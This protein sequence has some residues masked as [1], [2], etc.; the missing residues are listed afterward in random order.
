MPVSKKRRKNGTKKS[1]KVNR[2]GL[3]PD[4]LPPLQLAPDYETYLSNC[5]EIGAQGQKFHLEKYVRMHVP[6]G[7]TTKY[8]QEILL[9]AHEE[10]LGVE[11]ERV[12]GD[13]EMGF[14]Q[15]KGTT[16]VSDCF[17]KLPHLDEY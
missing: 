13:G 16:L 10:K 9:P 1:G 11:L 17:I 6:L 4:A 2:F 14:Y 7:Y 12:G 3:F 15:V 5:K 8:F